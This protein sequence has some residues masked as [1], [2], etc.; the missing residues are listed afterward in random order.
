MLFYPAGSKTPINY[1]GERSLK[2]LTKF[3]KKNAKKPFELP[4]KNKDGKEEEE[5]PKDEL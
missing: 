1:E 2:D 4:K 3:I 5:A